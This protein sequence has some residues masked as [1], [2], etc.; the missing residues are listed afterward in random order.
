MKKHWPIDAELSAGVHRPLD[1]TD[2]P[3]NVGP[4]LTQFRQAQ[5]CRLVCLSSGM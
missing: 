1:E 4:Q 5:R 2:F 3:P